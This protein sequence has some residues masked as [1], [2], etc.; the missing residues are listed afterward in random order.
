M[1]KQDKLK[2]VPIVDYNLLKIIRTITAQGLS[3]TIGSPESLG[4]DKLTID[5]IN[6]DNA[7]V[8]VDYYNMSVQEVLELTG[9]YVT[10]E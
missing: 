2:I 9:H 1:A 8:L 7:E 6:Q 3:V 4:L 5:I 10:I